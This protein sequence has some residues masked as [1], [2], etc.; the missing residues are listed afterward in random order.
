MWLAIKLDWVIMA[1][2]IVNK[3]AN[4]QTKTYQIED[5]QIKTEYSSD[6]NNNLAYTVLFLTKLDHNSG[7]LGLCGW[8]SN[9]T[10]MLCKKKQ[11]ESL[12]MIRL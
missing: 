1:I 10:K 12:L 11:A 5:D 3:F 9:L 8:K 2:N 4:N 6:T 7:M